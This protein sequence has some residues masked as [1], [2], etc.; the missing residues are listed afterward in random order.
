MK[1]LI[2]KLSTKE[3]NR[4]IQEYR[5]GDIKAAEDLLT[6]FKPLIGKFLKVFFSGVFNPSDK[7]IT[8]FL[9]ACGKIDVHRTAEIMKLRLRKYDAEEL[10]N[11]AKIALLD[12]AK[13]YDNISASYK[14]VLHK[15]LK[16][17]LWED[18]PNGMPTL[19]LDSIHEYPDNRKVDN[20][21][22]DQWLA[23]NT[24]GPGFSD[25]TKEQRLLVKMLWE[26]NIPSIHVAMKLGIS[27]HELSKQKD[28][29][30]S[31]LSKAL[32]IKT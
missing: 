2:N 9:H 16:S 5:L 26:E 22:D 27:N 11:I 23:G 13:H 24:T 8:D 19:E 20:P 6:C 32:N 25:L 31:I 21:I 10:I 1:E 14:Y 18:F 29:I 30:K 28:E 3:I 15:Y 17:M 4:L 7:D 12:T